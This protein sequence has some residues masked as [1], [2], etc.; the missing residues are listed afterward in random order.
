MKE[1]N[2]FVPK[3]YFC[4]KF[5]NFFQFHHI[6]LTSSG[7]YFLEVENPDVATVDVDNA[8][9]TAGDRYHYTSIFLRD[10]NVVLRSDVGE[11]ELKSPR[12][13]LHIVEPD[14]ISIDIDPYKS[15]IVLIGNT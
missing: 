6:D 9:V 8:V 12:A 7:Q 1:W 11:V 5:V 4:F 10:K 3:E 15:W 2:D 14:H 13:D